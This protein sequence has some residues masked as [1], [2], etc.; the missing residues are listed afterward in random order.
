MMRFFLFLSV[1]CL[2]SAAWAVSPVLVHTYGTTNSQVENRT[3]NTT[4]NIPNVEPVISGNCFGVAF[5]WSTVN[6]NPTVSVSDDQSDTFYQ[7]AENPVDSTNHDKMQVWMTPPITSGAK[8]AVLT[9]NNL[10]RFGQAITFEVAN[11][12]S[13]SVAITDGHA[14][15]AGSGTAI[16]AGSLTPGTTADLLLHFAF[17]DKDGT[18]PMLSSASL[19][20][21]SNITWAQRHAELLD[22]ELLNYG[23]YN[24]TSAIN[25]QMTVA[26]SSAFISIAIAI[27]GA[28]GGGTPSGIVVNSIQ[29]VNMRSTATGGAGYSN[30]SV[31]QFPATGNALV[32]VMGAGCD[33]TSVTYGSTGLSKRFT[34]TGTGSSETNQAFDLLNYSPDNT[35]QITITADLSGCA[36]QNGYDYDYTLI[37]YDVSYAGT[38]AYDTHS[39]ASG[40]VTSCSSPCSLAGASLT[41]GTSLGILFAV[42]TEWYNNIN[43]V[44]SPWTSDGWAT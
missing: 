10:T 3:G 28:A 30:P 14:S 24:S 33:I 18:V 43:G 25:P 29:D 22:G 31:T 8:Y 4:F 15:N 17:I 39:V 41:P 36:S 6:T 27:K 37:F 26:P 1:I 16:T 21:Q 11:C 2:S 34:Y 40:D 7:V 5:K 12:G 35:Q 38:W 20:S 32:S 19:F 23:I 13:T 44:S 9:F 42:A